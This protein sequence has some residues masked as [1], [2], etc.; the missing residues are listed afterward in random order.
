MIF[1]IICDAIIRY[2]L[3]TV[4]EDGR[5]PVEGLSIHIQAMVALFYV[6]DG[7]IASRSAE[8][9]QAAVD[10]VVEL[11]SRMGLRT[12]TSKTKTMTCM[13]GFI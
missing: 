3:S 1:N 12:N 10:V 8:W 13:P 11:F 2:W 4:S 6:D 9:L 7:L 5:D